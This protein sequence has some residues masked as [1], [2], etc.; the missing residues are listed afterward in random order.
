[1]LGVEGEILRETEADT[2]RLIESERD[3]ERQRQWER[4]GDRGSIYSFP[5]NLPV[6]LC[7]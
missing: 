7:Q 4:E 3:Q 2:E 5:V 1:M 6:S